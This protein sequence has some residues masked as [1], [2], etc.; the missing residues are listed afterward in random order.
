[1]KTK[2]KERPVIGRTS[3]IK[4]AVNASLDKYKL[5]PGRGGRRTEPTRQLLDLEDE[6]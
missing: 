1:M 3:E 6:A 4:R 5:L 2:R